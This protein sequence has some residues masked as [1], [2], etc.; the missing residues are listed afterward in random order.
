MMQKAPTPYINLARPFLLTTS[1]AIK[2]Q[3]VTYKT[4]KYCTL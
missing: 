1:D 4:M 3:S 2:Q